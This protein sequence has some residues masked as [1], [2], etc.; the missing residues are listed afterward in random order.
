MTDIRNTH[1]RKERE[2]ER[3]KL[4]R[5][6]KK[7]QLRR[8]EKDA[9]KGK[10]GERFIKTMVHSNQCC[11]EK[12]CIQWVLFSLKVEVI[13]GLADSCFRGLMRQ[14]NGLSREQR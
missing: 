8:W 7:G 10:E 13:G 2:R 9:I 1:T 5:E 14:S 6:H 3:E 4:K 11:G 12:C